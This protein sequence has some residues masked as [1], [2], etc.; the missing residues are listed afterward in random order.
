MLEWKS[1]VLHDGHVVVPKRWLFIHYYEALNILF[2]TENALRVFFYLVLKSNM[3]QRWQDAEIQISDTEKSTIAKVA[4]RRIVQ[5]HGYGY[6]GYE[7]ASP[8][9]HLN[10]GELTRLTMSKAYTPCHCWS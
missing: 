10:S 5:A 1:A 3:H 7:I 9:M 2:R 8:L 6:L 4:T